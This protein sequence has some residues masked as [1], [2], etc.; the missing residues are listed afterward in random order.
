MKTLAT[1]VAFATFL[2]APALG[3]EGA[4]KVLEH[5]WKLESASGVSELTGLVKVPA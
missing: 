5:G 1:I 3:E 2:A 4:K